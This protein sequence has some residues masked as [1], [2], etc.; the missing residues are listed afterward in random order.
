MAPT[1]R[2]SNHT[3]N[4]RSEGSVVIIVMMFILVILALGVALFS[5]VKFSIGGTELE[6]KEVKAFN[7]AE[8]GVDTG[9][10]TL[11]LQW[12]ATTAVAV[13]ETA[14]RA[15]FSTT[16]FPNPTSGAG[17]FINVAFYDDDNSTDELGPPTSGS[18]AYDANGNG[19]MWVDSEANSDNDRHR[20]MVLTQRETWNLSLPQHAMYAS[21]VIGNGPGL[22]VRVDPNQ[23]MHC[24][25]CGLLMATRPNDGF[26]PG[27]G[28]RLPDLPTKVAAWYKTSEGKPIN[29]DPPS[30]K[31]T[32][33][34]DG[35]TFDNMIST[36]L[37]HALA[38]IAQSQGTYYDDVVTAAPSIDWASIDTGTTLLKSANGPGKIIYMK[39]ATPIVIAANTQLGSRENPIVLI[40]DCPGIN[41]LD[42][43]G[44]ADFFGSIV[45][46]GSLELRG[47]SSFWGQIF[48]RDDL[49]SK[50]GGTSPEINYNLDIINRINQTYTISV[51]IVPNTWEEYTV[52]R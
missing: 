52:A 44:G 23:P 50:G 21:N 15:Q 41:A 1:R 3:D 14:F 24:P 49:E 11:K 27:C 30:T 31:A 36:K 4:G 19:R 46:T 47:T 34:P 18:P 32:V 6:R 48:A 29:D 38:G 33:A 10:R 16:N 42:F 51:A 35:M 20:I 40:L 9:M 45:S 8:A 28:V 37:I 39:S 17:D 12:P 43:R 25:Q 26:C 5:M 13:D 7:V 2:T 22:R